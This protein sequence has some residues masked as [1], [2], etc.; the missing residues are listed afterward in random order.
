MATDG[1]D[2]VVE[3]MRENLRLNGVGDDGVAA[4]RLWW[5]AELEGDWI[6]GR[7]ATA[8]DVVIGADI[9]ST[10][11]YVFLRMHTYRASTVA[12]I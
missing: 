2:R 1:E 7:D 3:G 12:Y 8:I 11:L 4:R 5:G 6:D 9:V 10:K